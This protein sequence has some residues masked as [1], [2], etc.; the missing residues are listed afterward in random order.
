MLDFLAQCQAAAIQHSGLT[1]ALFFA[2]LVG[3]FTHCAGMCGPFVV[4]Q[5]TARL[6]AIP[7][8]SMREWRRLSG[9]ALMPY[10]L[11]RMTTYTLLGI[12]AALLAAQVKIYPVFPL[13]SAAL[14]GIAAIFFIGSSVKGLPLTRLIHWLEKHFTFSRYVMEIARPFFGQPTGWNG[15]VLG[16]LLGFMPCGM[17][18]AAL[19]AVAATGDPVGAALG[20]IAFSI[21]TIPALFLI[22]VGARYLFRRNLGMLRPVARGIMAA[23]SIVLLI[24]AGKLLA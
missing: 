12:I 6:E 3:G 15:Y 8:A 4:G 13:I 14:L 18:F 10:H 21:G 1:A 17:V 2:G 20:M 9:A 23:N 16:T 24:M 22:G 19:M 11:G 7:A 5:S